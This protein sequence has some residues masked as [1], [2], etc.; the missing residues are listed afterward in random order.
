MCKGAGS[1]SFDMH[2]LFKKIR[3]HFSTA[4]CYV[5]CHSKS[6][7]HPDYACKMICLLFYWK[8]IKG[9]HFWISDILVAV[10]ED[11]RNRSKVSAHLFTAISINIV[12]CAH[13]RAIIF[14]DHCQE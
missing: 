13:I 11:K 12:L 7:E 9:N 3:G 6:I 2:Y 4:C 14:Y 10:F 8:K 1:N 5:T